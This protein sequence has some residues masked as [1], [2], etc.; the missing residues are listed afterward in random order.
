MCVRQPTH[1]IPTLVPSRARSG[2]V[3]DAVPNKN[4]DNIFKLL[5]DCMVDFTIRGIPQDDDGS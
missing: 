3:T 1:H 4:M 5:G 2:Q